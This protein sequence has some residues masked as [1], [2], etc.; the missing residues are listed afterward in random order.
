MD[1][2]IKI[3]CCFILSGQIW[4]ISLH[5]QDASGGL[6]VRGKIVDKKTKEAL[7][8]VSVSE[9]DADGRFLKGAATDISG[10]YI[11]KITNSKNKISVSYVGYQTTNIN[12][13]GRSTINIEMETAQEKEME[14]VVIV[15]Q[16]NVD[17]GMVATGSFPSL[18]EPVVTVSSST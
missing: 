4:C 11:L 16:R 13:N 15:A 9:M 17:N 12:I 3:F 14:Q 10:N 2:V 7:Q 1:K 8:G 18:K 6:V 5:A